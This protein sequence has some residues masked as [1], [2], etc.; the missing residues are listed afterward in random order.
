MPQ[1][2][3]NSPLMKIEAVMVYIGRPMR[4]PSRSFAVR[5]C[6]RLIAIKPCRKERDGNTGSATNGHS[7]PANREMNSE[8]EYSQTSNSRLPDMRSKISRGESM[9][10]KLRSTR[11]EEYTS[12]LQSRQYLV[13]RLLL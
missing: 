10:M 12:E 13:C 11:S 9:L 1:S 2:C 5:I 3:C 7:L 4:L 6:L 8:L